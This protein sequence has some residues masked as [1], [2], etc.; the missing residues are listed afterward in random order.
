VVTAGASILRAAHR[1]QAAIDDVQGAALAAAAIDMRRELAG[2][3]P[4]GFL[5]ATTAAHLP[6]LDRYL[7]ALATRAERAR[8]NPERDSERMAEVLQLSTELEARLTTLR[9]AR[10]TD[11]DVAAARRMLQEFRVAQFAQPMRTAIPVS[12]KRIRTAIAALH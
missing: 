4:T 3:L 10:L 2:L 9:P 6:D 12:A 11:P 7:Q 8:Q 1:A 5:T